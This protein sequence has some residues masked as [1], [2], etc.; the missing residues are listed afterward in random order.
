[1]EYVWSMPPPLLCLFFKKIIWKLWFF[2]DFRSKFRCLLAEIGYESQLSKIP[3]H[4]KLNQQEFQG[5][6]KYFNDLNFDLV[7]TINTVV[8]KPF[9]ESL[10][11][12]N[13][14]VV[15]EFFLPS[16]FFF[17]EMYI[18]VPNVI[19]MLLFMKTSNRQVVSKCFFLQSWP[20]LCTSLWALHHP[21][22]E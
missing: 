17:W 2:I 4:L 7:I 20:T 14:Y 5:L 12:I 11:M 22:H 16:S 3:K 19:Y 13:C 6:K 15:I 10:L 9:R 21:T 8:K 18:W 1:M